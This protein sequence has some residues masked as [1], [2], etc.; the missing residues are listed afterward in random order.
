MFEFLNVVAAAI[1]VFILGLAA[2]S[3]YLQSKKREELG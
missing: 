2:H 1:A 3:A